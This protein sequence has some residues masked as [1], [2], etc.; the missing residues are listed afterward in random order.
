MPKKNQYQ[1]FKY[2]IDKEN[3][4]KKLLEQKVDFQN[5][6]NV[7]PQEVLPEQNTP[8][9]NMFLRIF[10]V[11]N[12]QLLTR[13]ILDAVDIFNNFGFEVDQA[14]NETDKNNQNNAIEMNGAGD[15]R[16]EQQIM[17]LY[18]HISNI[19]PLG[20][21]YLINQLINEMR[22]LC[23]AGEEVSGRNI[24]LFLENADDQVIQQDLQISLFDQYQNP[25][26]AEDIIPLYQDIMARR[27]SRYL[28]FVNRGDDGQVVST[29]I[30]Q[31][32]F[33]IMLIMLYSNVTR[34]NVVSATIENQQQQGIQDV[35]QQEN[36]IEVEEVMRSVVLRGHNR[37]F[38]NQQIQNQ[39][40]MNLELIQ[41]LQQ[42]Q[43]GQLP[44]QLEDITRLTDSEDIKYLN[45]DPNSDMI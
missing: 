37:G 2:S 11:F 1:K 39:Q 10:R 12:T 17:P 44:N 14:V 26:V 33:V 41:N 4:K 25:C 35:V 13:A 5:Q 28:E 7:E 38:D 8:L 27:E 45:C 31:N 15:I 40:Q 9:A 43:A 36:N 6:V 32:V 19:C 16:N 18:N 42:Q 21:I 34:S 29:F 23:L 30:D 22:N 20:S 3:K 24:E